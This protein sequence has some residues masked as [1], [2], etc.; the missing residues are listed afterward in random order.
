MQMETV[1]TTTTRT[2]RRRAAVQALA[3]VGFITLIVLGIMLAIYTARFVPEAVSRVGSAA[4]YLA[5]V[6]TPADD[7]GLTVVPQIPFEENPIVATSTATTTPPATPGFIAPAVPTT[8][9]PT[10]PAQPTYFGLADLS[11]QITAVGYLRNNNDINSFVATN[12]IPDDRDGLV[13]F[14]VS[15][16][17]TNQSGTYEIEIKIKT[18]SATDTD[19][20]DGFNLRPG[21]AVSSYATFDANRRG[22]VDITLTVDSGNDVSDSNEGNNTATRELE[23]SN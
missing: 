3:I 20:G 19:T 12:D 9:A 22:D 17:G 11:V 16:R 2:I 10:L 14:T 13:K 6:F 7:E 23:V 18:G 4:V 21:A 5:E 8:P 15:N 1:S